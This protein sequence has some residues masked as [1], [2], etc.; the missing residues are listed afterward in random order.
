MK[1]KMDIQSEITAH[2]TLHTISFYGNGYYFNGYNHHIN[3]C[4]YKFYLQIN[5][6]KIYYEV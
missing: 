3:Y 6:F 1:K 4:N 5:F 2:R